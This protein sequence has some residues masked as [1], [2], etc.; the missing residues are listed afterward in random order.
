MKK[1]DYAGKEEQEV[2]L[3]LSGSGGEGGSA[4]SA[5]AY[6]GFDAG[7][8]PDPF[9]HTGEGPDAAS[10]GTGFEGG[11]KNL[12][13]RWLP[14]LFLLAML[15]FAA[16]G[17]AKCS[18]G[19]EGAVKVGDI[20]PSDKKASRLST[21]TS[22][23]YREQLHLYA[24]GRAKEALASGGSFIEPAQGADDPPKVQEQAPKPAPKPAEPP[25]KKEV[26]KVEAKPDP[27]KKAAKKDPV[28]ETKAQKAAADRSKLISRYLS[29]LVQDRHSPKGRTVLFNSYAKQD[30][31][32]G[33]TA[34]AA[35]RGGVQGDKP[36]QKPSPKDASCGVPGMQ[37]GDIL[38][39]VNRVTID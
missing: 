31:M 39:A 3:S 6:A 28:R 19:S 17:L 21:R 14:W 29:T 35:A 11:A 38:Y 4:D 37:A 34:A 20:S 32:A 15:A 9:D 33:K 1:E 8:Y 2:P 16:A 27:P 22:P 25:E 13:P 36:S 30:D 23:A 5:D 12:V 7:S 10:A 18:K 24:E 26:P